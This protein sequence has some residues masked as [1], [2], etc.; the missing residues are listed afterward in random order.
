MI[1]KI[2][3]LSEKM[4]Q[5]LNSQSL[6]IAIIKLSALGDIVH[7]SIVL[8][9]IKK[10]LESAGINYDISWI[11][12]EKFAEILEGHELISNLIKIPLKDK[13]FLR[14]YKILKDAGKFHIAVD[15]QGLIKS[16][17][18]AK[19]L[20]TKI[21]YG[22]DK[23]SAKESLASTFYTHKFSCDYNE[24][25]IIRNLSLTAFALGFKFERDEI[26][27]K[28]PCLMAYEKAE[29]NEPKRIL[30]APFASEESKCYDK[31]KR[32]I[33]M[34]SNYKVHVCFGN[35]KEFDKLEE[36]V[37]YT[38]ADVLE[39]MSLKELVKFINSCDLVIGN[40][41]GITH[42]AW[43]QNIPSITL[44]GN[45]PSQRNAYTTNKNIVIDAC[46]KIDARKIDKNDFCIREIK[47][48]IIA[49]A[50]ERILNA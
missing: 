44:F 36:I 28:K 20:D 42:I 2:V 7:A 4:S 37:K 33:K 18:V 15:L 39:K 50:A 23:N 24:N 25:I 32:V 48:E 19:I 1:P 11:V 47:P 40:D 13:K 38:S 26:L 27:N 49:E 12:D 43:A 16:A 46:K 21:I 9:F 14:T 22:F 45:R 30:I 6:K 41:S 5:D 31:F 29:K 35:K 17:I 34:L 10:N 8:E 3:K